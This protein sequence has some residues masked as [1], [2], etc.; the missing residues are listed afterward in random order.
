MALRVSAI[1]YRVCCYR[2]S[3]PYEA[4]N[5]ILTAIGMAATSPVDCIKD[6]LFLWSGQSPVLY[7]HLNGVTRRIKTVESREADSKHE[8]HR[9]AEVLHDHPLPSTSNTQKLSL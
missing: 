6:Q 7:A 2:F 5:S 3:L 1:V 8:K 4:G 9:H